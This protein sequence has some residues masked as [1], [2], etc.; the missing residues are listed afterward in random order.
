MIDGVTYALEGVF[1]RLFNDSSLTF[2]RSGI[3]RRLKTAGRLLGGM[4]ELKTVSH[5]CKSGTL[6]LKHDDDYDDDDDNND[7]DYHA[8]ASL[9]VRAQSLLHPHVIHIERVKG[10]KGEDRP[11]T[12]DTKQC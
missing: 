9:W 12:T 8:S 1:I 4:H 7:Y 3:S 10:L 6:S 2:V 5:R 11:Q